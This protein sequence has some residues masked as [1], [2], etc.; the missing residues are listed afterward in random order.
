[1]IDLEDE[2]Q[3]GDLCWLETLVN[4]TGE[5]RSVYVLVFRVRTLE[6]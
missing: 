1:M 5:S 2:F 4:P 3:P 6:V